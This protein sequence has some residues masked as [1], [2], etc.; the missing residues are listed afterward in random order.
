MTYVRPILYS[1]ALLAALAGCVQ[2][3]LGPRV[4]VMPPPNKP[5]DVFAAEDSGCRQYANQQVAGGA[6][7]ANN[8]QVGSAVVGTVLGAA[9]GAAV[10]GG[11][12]AAIGAGSGA[13]IGT[14]AGSGPGANA[15][16]SLQ[17][18]YDI[19]Y[20]QC[21]YSHGNQV[22]GYYAARR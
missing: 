18:R 7:Q 19:S 12:G 4:M 11:R 1:I 20:S 14:A 10:G 2:P 6:E 5:F 22:P 8:Q 17:Q 16:Y 3:P 15:Q 13:I 21:M 9:L